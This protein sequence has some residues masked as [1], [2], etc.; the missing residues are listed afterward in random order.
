MELAKQVPSLAVLVWL[1]IQFNKTIKYAITVFRE[2]LSEFKEDRRKTD[3]VIERNTDVLAH[4][5]GIL[6]VQ[7][8]KPGV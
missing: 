2:E 6:M 1:V 3:S 7:K 4:V 8:S 5:K